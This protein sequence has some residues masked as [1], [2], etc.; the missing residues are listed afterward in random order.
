MGVSASHLQQI[1]THLAVDP[2]ERVRGALER[3]GREK[4]RGLEEAVRGLEGN[5]GRISD[6]V[7]KAGQTKRSENGSEH[8]A[9]NNRFNGYNQWWERWELFKLAVVRFKKST[10]LKDSPLPLR[11]LQ[12]LSFL[13]VSISTPPNALR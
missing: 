3:H 8:E 2:Y 5:G 7:E 6:V 13:R 4:L 12:I 1:G 10:M 11:V 9:K